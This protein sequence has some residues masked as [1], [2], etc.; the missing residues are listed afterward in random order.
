[1]R[2]KKLISRTN[3]IFAGGFEGRKE[4]DGAEYKRLFN[5]ILLV[6]SVSVL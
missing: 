5:I 3:D 6:G 2:R 1:M 4:N